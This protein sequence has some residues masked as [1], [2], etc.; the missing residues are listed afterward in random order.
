[1]TTAASV[2]RR[3]R[4]TLRRRLLLQVGARLL[5]SGVAIVAL[6][7]I[8]Q[9]LDPS[10]TLLAVIGVAGLVASALPHRMRRR[11]RA[12]EISN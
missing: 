7:V 9:P 1:M 3:A 6:A 5:A 4:R 8:P 11:R 2:R 10:S 12:A